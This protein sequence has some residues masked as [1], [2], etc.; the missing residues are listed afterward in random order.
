MQFPQLQ[1]N[2]IR[3][4][5]VGLLLLLPI[6]AIP[7]RINVIYSEE[8]LRTERLVKQYLESKQSPLA[9]HTDYL[10]Q[11][12]DWKLLVAVSA[13]ESQFCKRKIDFNCWGIGGDSLYRHYPGYPEAIKDAQAVIEYWHDKGRWMTVEDMN[14]SYVKPCNPNWVRVVN[15]VLNEIE[16]IINNKDLK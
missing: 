1:G 3:A 7:S 11:Q 13:I 14:C 15:H 8:P 6:L 9:E 16:V 2:R 12:E 4:V 5:A 10:L